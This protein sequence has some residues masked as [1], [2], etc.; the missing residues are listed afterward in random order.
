MKKNL[1]FKIYSVIRTLISTG[2][3]QQLCKFNTFNYKILP[4]HIIHIL[5]EYVLNINNYMFIVQ[6]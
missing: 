5:H 1:Y 6:Y 4:N 3:I 2:S